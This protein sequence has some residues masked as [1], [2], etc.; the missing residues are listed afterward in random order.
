MKFSAWWSLLPSEDSLYFLQHNGRYPLESVL[1]YKV[2]ENGTMRSIDPPNERSFVFSAE[3]KTQ[4][5]LAMVARPQQHAGCLCGDGLSK[6]ADLTKAVLVK[7]PLA[8]HP[9]IA[10]AFRLEN[11]ENL[12][13]TFSYE[14]SEPGFYWQWTAP[15]TGNYEISSA[16]SHLA[17]RNLDIFRGADEDPEDLAQPAFPATDENPVVYHFKAGQQVTMRTTSTA[18]TDQWKVTSLTVAK[19]QPPRND[20]FARAAILGGTI[21]PNDELTL[22]G[23][24]LEA[25]EPPTDDTGTLWWT[26]IAPS[27]GTWSFKIPRGGAVNLEIF[28]GASLDQL[29][30]TG[31]QEWIYART[32][33]VAKGEKFHLRISGKTS[34]PVLLTY[35]KD[36]G[37]F[38]D[39]RSRAA[40][41]GRALPISGQ[42]MLA[43]ATAEEGEPGESNLWWHWT[44]PEDGLVCFAVP[45]WGA[46]S[47]TMRVYLGQPGGP[48]EGLTVA[49]DDLYGNGSDH[50]RIIPVLKGESFLITLFSSSPDIVQAH[51][52]VQF[53]LDPVPTTPGNHFFNR[54]DLG[55]GK[56]AEFRGSSAGMTMGLDALLN[57]HETIWFTWTCPESGSYTANAETYRGISSD[58]FILYRGTEV[59]QLTRLGES[60]E[61][62]RPTYLTFEATTGTS[63][64]IVLQPDGPM[65]DYHLKIFSPHSYE[66]WLDYQIDWGGRV[67]PVPT[68]TRDREDIRFNDGLSNFTRYVHGLSLNDTPGRTD[69]GLPVLTE[70]DGFLRLQYSLGSTASQATAIPI[71]HE[72]QVSLD[73]K[74]W[75]PVTPTSLGNRR[76][77][78][79]TPISEKRKF[80]RLRLW[81][82]R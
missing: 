65:E 21:T 59:S 57:S 77:L 50:K 27:P 56:T 72:G 26:W 4:Y 16:D 36:R 33:T 13:R 45:R 37:P 75:T 11:S 74:T 71:R 18:S 3:N 48:L 31:P 47:K 39:L 30:A 68:T 44:A 62:D 80:L 73:G 5:Y 40:D 49:C 1:V 53:T 8:S 29:T 14:Q 66:Q 22:R 79:E 15:S 46:S 25:G 54:I 63:Y 28:Q 34:D 38:N 9:S 42:G 6:E 69:A 76:F 12:S 64:Q 82:E 55:S 35:H 19:V 51:S 52:T 41:L 23:S 2:F 7:A 60:D 24:S 67:W 20:N 32:L 61:D 10:Q 43:Q 58:G 78:V 81:E 17:G 70:A